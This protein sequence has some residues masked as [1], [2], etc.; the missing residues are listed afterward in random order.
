[1]P[2]LSSGWHVSH[3]SPVPDFCWFGS[4]TT[5]LCSFCLQTAKLLEVTFCG[6][7]IGS[8][9]QCFAAVVSSNK[10]VDDLYINSEIQ[11]KF[12][13]KPLSF[14]N[15][16]F[17]FLKVYGKEGRNS[18]LLTAGTAQPYLYCV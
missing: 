12:L 17:T 9:F 1:M 13:L 11:F 14:F 4:Q 2:C 10:T 7:R 18:Q 6:K 5:A 8:L 16:L 3:S 15:F